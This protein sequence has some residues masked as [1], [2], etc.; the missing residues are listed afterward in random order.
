MKEFPN[1]FKPENKENFSKYHCER[2]I[3]Y[4]RR[5][6]FELVIRGDENNYFDI[7]KFAR[8]RSLNKN[9]IEYILKIVMDELKKLGWNVK[10]SFG[11]TGLFIYS[12]EEPPPSCYVD[13]L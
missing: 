5:D 13:E 6:I 9:E 3:A 1:R 11:G 7:D 10:T 12:S 4:M 2:N 8:N